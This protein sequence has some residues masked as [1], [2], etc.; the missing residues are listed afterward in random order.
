MSNRLSYGIYTGATFGYME[1]NSTVVLLVNHVGIGVHSGA[2][3]G[4]WTETYVT[5]TTDTISP[6]LHERR[7]EGW[8]TRL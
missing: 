6:S 7:V 4:M 1:D 3:V 5:F 2:G 8:R